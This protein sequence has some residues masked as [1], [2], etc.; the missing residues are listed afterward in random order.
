M[1]YVTGTPLN[2]LIPA[3]GLRLPTALRYAV[4]VADALAA[5]H[6]AGIV[7]RDLKPSNVMVTESGLVK[8][9]D[10]GIAKLTGPTPADESAGS[11]HRDDAVIVPHRG[12]HRSG[13]DRLH[14]ARA[15]RRPGGRCALGH[16][17]FRFR[18]STRCSRAQG[19]RGHS[20]RSPR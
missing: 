18:D 9:L 6:A 11:E 3:A 12:R 5:T 8:V 16:L 7:H 4:Q 1:E 2:D 14:V 13:H 17:Q 20:R 10:F 19:V 15:G